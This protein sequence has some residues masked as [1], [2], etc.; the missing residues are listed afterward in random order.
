MN[1]STQLR[2]GKLSI[3]F[4]EVSRFESQPHERVLLS[5][6]HP[7][8]S[9][10][11]KPKQKPVS[12][13]EDAIH[14]MHTWE[15]RD[16]MVLKEACWP[17]FKFGSGYQ[18]LLC[19]GIWGKMLVALGKFHYRWDVPTLC[20]AVTDASV[21]TSLHGVLELHKGIF[22]P[23]YVETRQRLNA[24][25]CTYPWQVCLEGNAV[26]TTQIV[27]GPNSSAPWQRLQ[28]AGWATLASVK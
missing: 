21:K 18:E 4:A 24:C 3:S 13:S 7:R 17:W 6:H 19:S 1:P 14:R 12:L 25:A 2:T 16:W 8:V 26:T 28:A 15:L 11:S 27:T 23:D 20:N 10:A 5:L 22:S 9:L